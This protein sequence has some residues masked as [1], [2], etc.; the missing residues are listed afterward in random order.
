LEWQLK[1]HP[2]V[3]GRQPEVGVAID[4]RLARWGD[5]LAVAPTGFFVNGVDIAAARN[6][7]DRQIMPVFPLLL[8][9]AFVP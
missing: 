6:A 1:C 8:C 5:S 3:I 4:R 2:N 9:S 7:A